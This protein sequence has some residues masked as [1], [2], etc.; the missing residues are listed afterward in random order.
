MNNTCM[1]LSMHPSLPLHT[2]VDDWY[3]D[4]H[5]GEEVLSGV[6]CC[7]SDLISFHYVGP[8]EARVIHNALSKTK[9]HLK[10]SQKDLSTLWP[11]QKELGGY[12]YPPKDESSTWDLLLRKISVCP[13]NTLTS[14]QKTR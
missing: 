9:Q 11:N 8:S 5:K 2:Q 10:L 7:S 14:K 13:T 1:H 3:R 12:S 6:D 4:D